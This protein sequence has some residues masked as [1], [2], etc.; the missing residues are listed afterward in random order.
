MDELKYLVFASCLK[1]LLKVS[2]SCGHI[3]IEANFKHTGSL[4]SVK[5][6]CLE[7]HK[8]IW[9]SQ[10]IIKST[11][12][13]NLLISSSI[14]F[15]GNT[16]TAVQNFASCLGLKIFRE[17]TFHNTQEQYL[18]PVISEKWEDERNLIVQELKQRE[19]KVI[20]SGV[21]RCDSLGY[22]AKYGTYTFM[23]NETQKIVDFTVVQ[24]TDVSLSNAMEKHGFQIGLQQLTTMKMSVGSS[25]L[26]RKV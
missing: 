11:P 13:G 1:Q 15:T 23:D 22:N 10:P 3:V 21:G 25:P 20:L 19:N 9:N 7:G 24:V 12:V 4:L 14:L 18:F 5:L 26:L 8:F 2:P 17:K 6:T 16:F